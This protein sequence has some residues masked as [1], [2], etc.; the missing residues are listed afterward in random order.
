[1]TRT[2]KIL[3]AIL[4]LQLALA[5]VIRAGGDISTIAKP[6][7]VLPGF[8]A[9]AVER[10]RIN[11]TG[12]GDDPQAGASEQVVELAR[13]GEDWALASH[14]DYPADKTKVAD[15]LA[16]LGAMTSRGPIATN[17]SRHRQ[18]EVSAEAFQR[19][20]VLTAKGGDTVLWIGGSV[21]ARNT[22]VRVDGANEVYGVAKLSP[23]SISAQP[24]GWVDPQYFQVESAQVAS[25]MIANETGTIEL[26]RAD[27]GW[28][29]LQNGVEL[30][31]PEGKQVD[32]A[33]I[34]DVI[35][36][37]TSVRLA[38]PTDPAQAPAQMPV[39]ITIRMK[40]AGAEAAGANAA[41][42][43]AGAEPAAAA[44]DSQSEAAADGAVLQA[45]VEYVLEI[46]PDVDGKRFVR[47]VG[48]TRAVLVSN[49]DVEPI[50]G[51]TAE[52]LWK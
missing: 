19:K 51:L 4:V 44:A 33:A 46:G 2:N 15:L 5:A 49:Y 40:P 12:D 36:K 6:Q 52:T 42:S 8:D 18:L 37:A 34:D 14:F 11:T 13:V 27:Q 41:P 32:T 30:K 23:F 25:L 47:Q 26:R 39:R 10:V 7:S 28:Q 48:N 45:P 3:G 31:A 50:V 9:G 17:A 38:E 16:K 1:M 20:V 35:R 22:A 21:G 43:E 29:A 24:S